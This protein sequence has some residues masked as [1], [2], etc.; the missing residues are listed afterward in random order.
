ML[1]DVCGVGTGAG[2]RGGFGGRDFLL[3]RLAA[4]YAS[5]GWSVVVSTAASGW[6]RPELRCL[7]WHLVRSVVRPFIR[8]VGLLTRSRDLPVARVRLF[9]RSFRSFVRS[10]C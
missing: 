9:V 7:L 5:G 4:V 6:R 1:G 3:Q 2:S 8:L 10:C